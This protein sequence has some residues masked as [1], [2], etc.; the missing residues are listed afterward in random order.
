VRAAIHIGMEKTGTTSIQAFLRTNR[1]ALLDQGFLV[2]TS[3]GVLPPRVLVMLGIEEG[4]LLGDHRLAGLGDDQAISSF[5]AGRLSEFNAEIA[6]TS[7]RTVILTN[8]RLSS[9]LNSP[10]RVQRFRTWVDKH[11]TEGEI[12]V[13]LRRQDEMHLAMYSTN[14]KT[15]RTSPFRVPKD[16]DGATD[17][18]DYERMLGLWRDAFAGW[19]I[20]VGVFERDQ[21]VDGN[22]VQD[23][24][25][26]V[27]IDTESLPMPSRRNLSYGWEALEF[28][29][30][31]NRHIPYVSPSTDLTGRSRWSPGISEL[32]GGLL[33]AL[34][35]STSGSAALEW[36]APVGRDEW[37]SRYGDGNAAIA[38]EYL[39]RP[40]GELFAAGPPPED[41]STPPE[42]TLDL[43]I[44]ISAGLW[45]YQRRRVI[46]LEE[47]ERTLRNQVR[48]LRNQRARLRRRLRQA[49]G[50]Q[51]SQQAPTLD[52]GLASEQWHWW[53]KGRQQ[54]RRLSKRI[55]REH[56]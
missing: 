3:L 18:Y 30:G 47:S 21:L 24:C 44:E 9:H 2:P 39:D 55:R 36:Y 53:E 29:R 23:F 22:V 41:P 50:A 54:A 34:E 7:P 38:R 43:A 32:R 6:A 56:G 52:A 48:E 33:A 19:P 31:M 51:A 35:Q 13:Y 8:E 5:V 49:E 26:L 27:G 4:S 37:L 10:E 40:S 15:G 46:E 25:D 20:Q 16:G 14:V 28:L 42:L 12:V 11:F 1:T 45:T 17:R